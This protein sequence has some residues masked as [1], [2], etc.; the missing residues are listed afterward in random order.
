MEAAGE[1]GS[2]KWVNTVEEIEAIEK[3]GRK[4]KGK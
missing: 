4:T 3:N 1:E 2:D